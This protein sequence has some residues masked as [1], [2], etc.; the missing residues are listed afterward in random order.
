MWFSGVAFRENGGSL[1]SKAASEKAAYALCLF[2][3][4]CVS[5]HNGFHGNCVLHW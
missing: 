1:L 5:K 4:R 2:C 3:R